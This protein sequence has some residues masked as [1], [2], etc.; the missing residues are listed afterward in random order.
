MQQWWRK[1]RRSEVGGD[2]APR[3]GAHSHSCGLGSRRGAAGCVRDWNLDQ[4]IWIDARWPRWGQSEEV[5]D[6]NVKSLNGERRVTGPGPHLSVRALRD[7]T[8]RLSLSV[9][10]GSA[11]RAAKAQGRG[12]PAPGSA[13]TLFNNVVMI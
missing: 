2:A 12:G 5:C 9:R 8:A 1:L 7:L 4:L 3:R 10:A 11:V 13:E 6:L